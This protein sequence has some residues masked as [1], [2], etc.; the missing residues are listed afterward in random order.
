MPTADATTRAP[1]VS[2]SVEG[3]ESAAITAGLAEARIGASNGNFYA[4]RI[5]RDLG[6]GAEDGVVRTSMVH[7]NTAEEVQRLVSRLDA[8]I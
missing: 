7:Y 3:Q 1:T 6:Y 4:Y 5:V 2:F 8:I